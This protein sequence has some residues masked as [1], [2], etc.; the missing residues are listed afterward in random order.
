MINNVT[1][2][3]EI[4]NEKNV[5]EES[6]FTRKDIK[7]SNIY[8]IVVFHI[9]WAYALITFP[10]IQHYITTLYSKIYFTFIPN[11]FD[12]KIKFKKCYSNFQLYSR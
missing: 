6:I 1:D 12:R 3:Q 8:K 9:I 10:Y 5:G 2:E 7:W 11:N 4:I